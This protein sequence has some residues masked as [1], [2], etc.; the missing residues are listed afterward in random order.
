[1]RFT[2]KN[3]PEFLK[4]LISILEK[5]TFCFIQL[6]SV[7]ARTWCPLR[8]ERFFLGPKSRFWPKDPTFAIQPQFWSIARLLPTDC[9]FP[10]WYQFFDFAFPSYVKK[11]GWRAKKSSQA[12]S[13][14]LLQIQSQQMMKLDV[15]RGMFVRMNWIRHLTLTAAEGW[16]WKGFS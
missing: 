15:C 10:H 1:M 2:Q 8:S 3:H 16:K 11:N 12:T 13:Q 14:G 5:G 4:R 9:S 6:F 7:V